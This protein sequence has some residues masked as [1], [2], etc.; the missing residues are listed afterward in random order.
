MAKSSAPNRIL[1]SDKGLVY[2]WMSSNSKFCRFYPDL[3]VGITFLGVQKELFFLWC[4]FFTVKRSFSGS[5]V[6]FDNQV[7]ISIDIDADS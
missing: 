1:A 6:G 7:S 2:F 3:L 5:M 4:V